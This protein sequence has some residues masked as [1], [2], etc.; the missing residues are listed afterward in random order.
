MVKI[1]SGVAAPVLVVVVVVVVIG[2]EHLS[3]QLQPELERLLSV[4][5]RSLAAERSTSGRCAVG[6]FLP[7]YL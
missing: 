3:L 5:Q 7:Q 4:C 1:G 6:N 2:R